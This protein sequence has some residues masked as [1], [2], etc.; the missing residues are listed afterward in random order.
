MN[1]YLVRHAEPDYE[2]DTITEEGHQQA[3]AVGSWFSDI[4]VDEIYHSSMGRA[5]IT[6][7]YI[8][9]EKGLT[10][11][12][13]DWARE[14]AWGKTQYLGD[15]RVSMSPWSVKDRVIQSEHRYPQGEEWRNVPDLAD[16][17]LTASYDQHCKDLDTF[18]AEHGYQREGQLYKA[19]EPNDK[20]VVL[21][22]HG[23]VISAL[24]SHLANIPFMQYISHM[25][26]DLTAVTKAC[27]RGEAGAIEPAQLIYVNS[28]I[29][30]G[31]K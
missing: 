14:L 31:I 6:A 12:P 20:T 19:V 24:I 10:A 18:L 1:L 11:Q 29:H 16:G 22:C 15:V 23:G 21:V 8:A 25:G 30:L 17:I 7:G 4:P 26:S 27:L 9:K 13:V 28:Q 3:A 5:G 2:N